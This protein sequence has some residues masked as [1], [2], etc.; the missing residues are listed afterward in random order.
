[1]AGLVPFNKNRLGLRRSGFEDFYNMLDD[2][3]ND[4]WSPRRSLMYDT[5]KLDVQENDK[6]YCIEAELPGVKKEEINLE[7]NEGRL[8]ISINRE[9]SID[10]EKKNYIHKER[11]FSSMQRSIYLADAKGDGVKAKLEEGVLNITVPKQEKLDSTVKIN[12]E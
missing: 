12:I 8:T 11:R 6:E 4:T 2:F 1:M 5:F 7:L 3:F 9:E 10:E